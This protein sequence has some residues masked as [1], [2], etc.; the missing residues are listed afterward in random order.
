MWEC[1]FNVGVNQNKK[2]S[3][4]VF[5]IRKIPLSQRV[6]QNGSLKIVKTTCV[7]MFNSIKVQQY[8]IYNS[9]GCLTELLLISLRL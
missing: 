9:P 3:H 2:E 7:C 4:T 8:C 1:S 5:L 6:L